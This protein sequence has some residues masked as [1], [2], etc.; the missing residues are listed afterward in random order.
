M[1]RELGVKPTKMLPTGL[2]DRSID[3]TGGASEAHLALRLDGQSP[4]T[5]EERPGD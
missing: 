5:G 2:V 3:S 1:L 4:S